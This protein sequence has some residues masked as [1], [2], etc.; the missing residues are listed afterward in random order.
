MTLALCLVLSFLSGCA[1]FAILTGFE[2]LRPGVPTATR[3]VWLT[4][5]F[6]SGIAFATAA[7]HIHALLTQ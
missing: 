7:P 2:G 5:C 1:L 4:L 6:T 3:T